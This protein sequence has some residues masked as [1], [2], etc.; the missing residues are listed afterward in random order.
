LVS[1]AGPIDLYLCN[2]YALALFRNKAQDKAL[3]MEKGIQRKLDLA[4]AGNWHLK[5]INHFNLSRLYRASGD[6]ASERRELEGVMQTT[7]GLKTDLDQIYLN[8][9]WASLESRSGNRFET[10]RHTWRACV[11]WLACETPEALGWRTS[12]LLFSHAM[13]LQPGD[14]VKVTMVL[15]DL[16]VQRAAEA[17]FPIPE[18]CGAAPTFVNI[19]QVSEATIRA[20]TLVPAD[21]LGIL[22]GST[23]ASEGPLGRAEHGT[24]AQ[25]VHALFALQAG[26]EVSHISTWL[27]DDEFGQTIPFGPEGVRRL[28]L[29]W[30]PQAALGVH[31]ETEDFD[32]A[33]FHLVQAPGVD[34]IEMLEDGRIR[35]RFKRYRGAQTVARSLE[36]VVARLMDAGRVTL[37]EALALR[38]DG[39]LDRKENTLNLLRR[40]ELSR[41]AI[42][43]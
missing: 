28:M 11:H 24:L 41:V 30:A 20:S 21:N 16:L 43:T 39:E 27:V 42:L 26:V 17:G 8:L 5:Y 13:R 29:R 9:T 7:V 14:T 31:P 40:L 34:A 12:L 36:P 15:H 3:A 37:E 18:S 35:C 1:V 2:I 19:C 33:S 32:L 10:L 38:Y 23:E 22:L 25:A 6:L 4:G